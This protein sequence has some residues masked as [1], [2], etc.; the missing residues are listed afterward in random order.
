MATVIDGRQ[1]ATE[2]NQATAKRTAKLATRGITPGIVVIL[3]GDDPASL[4]YT[5]NKHRRAEKMGIRSVL[6]KLPADVDQATVM[7]AIDR[8]NQDDTID[9][10]LVQEPLPAHLDG[11]AITN[12]IR[13]DKDIDGLHPINLGKLY[14]NQPG[15]YPVA[16]TPRGVMTILRH[17]NVELAGKNATL[18]GRSILVGKPLAAMLD[19]A[20]ATTTVVNRYTPN[21]SKVTRQAD[22]LVVAAGSPH[23]ITREDVKP[24]A[25]VIDVGI[26]R[27]PSGKLTGDVDFNDVRDIASLITPVP[28]G[29]G[30]MTIAS[31][32]AQTV[33]LAEWRQHGQE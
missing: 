3:V 5:R 7:A 6:E 18:V 24:G 22:I 31:L 16:C 20:N 14:A 28:G 17:Y 29:V 9:A 2:L 23:L 12:A 11:L 13:P 10:I 33:D 19:N 8:Y 32:M 21:L 30:P 26:N 15:H 1:L 25:V 4:I 27:L